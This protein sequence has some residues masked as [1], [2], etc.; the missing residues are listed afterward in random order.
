MHDFLHI[1]AAAGA[2]TAAS[3]GGSPL[4]I[5]KQ[6]F[7]P[8]GVKPVFLAAQILNFLIVSA[9]VYRFAIKPVL[10]TVDD[11]NKKIAEG[12]QYAEDMK[13][14]LAETDTKQADV[15]KQASLEGKKVIAEARDTAKAI[16]DK[17]SQDA[18]RN[19]EDIIKKG[20]EAVALERQQMLNDLRREVAQLVVTTANRVLARDLTPE[21]RARFNASATADLSKN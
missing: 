2:D 4:E 13:K 12:L 19:A 21:E 15:L 5:V 3:S 16:V 10:A 8:F 14:K 6:I 18:T 17:A 11:R 1:L 20:G 7:G 9:I